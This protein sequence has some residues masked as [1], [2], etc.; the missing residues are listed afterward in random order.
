MNS[1]SISILIIHRLHIFFLFFQGENAHHF[2]VPTFDFNLISHF[3]LSPVFLLNIQ[4]AKKGVSVI[5]LSFSCT[6]HT[7]HMAVISC[8]FVT[9]CYVRSVSFLFVCIWSVQSPTQSPQRLRPFTYKWH[10]IWETRYTLVPG[11]NFLHW[12]QWNGH[13]SPDICILRELLSLPTVAPHPMFL[14]VRYSHRFPFPVHKP[15]PFS[16]AQASVIVTVL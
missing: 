10:M 2:L 15:S 12:S 3:L 14:C 13:H 5:T 6:C 16:Q 1:F 9:T 7:F 11:Y 8:A 4:R